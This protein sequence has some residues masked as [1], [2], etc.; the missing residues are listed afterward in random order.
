[1]AL[2]LAPSSLG[3]CTIKTPSLKI[4]SPAKFRTHQE[5]AGAGRECLIRQE[6]ERQQREIEV[7]RSL[8]Q[9]Q[10]LRAEEAEK[11]R[12]EERKSGKFR[13]TLIRTL[14]VV[15]LLA[16]GGM[17]FGFL[18]KTAA[19]KQ[20]REA[21]AAR[22]K[23]ESNNR[24]LRSLLEEAARS[25][26]LL[27]QEKLA[28]G[29]A[30]VALAHL[31]RAITYEPGSTLVSEIAFAALNDWRFPLPMATLQG[32]E[33]WVS[34][35]QFSPDGKRIVTASW[36]KTARLWETE[37]GKLLATLQGHEG[38]VY[39]AQFSPDGKRI[40]TASLD[41][42]ARLW[43][44]ESGKLLATLQGH[45]NWVSSAQF[46]PDGKR[47]V[48]ASSDKTARLWTILPPSAGASPE[49]F[50][51]FLQYLAQRRLNKDGELMWI[52]STEL[53]TIHD[54]LA[55]AAHGSSTEGETPYLR[56][57]RHFVH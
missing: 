54:R 32:H 16:I 36:D 1:M 34:S 35:A 23:F 3:R 51:D 22:D 5:Q 9:E 53:A 42:T 50:R 45:E 40:V 49:W 52:P 55:M 20:K 44:T 46:S 41:K 39:N 33:D 31:A 57:L 37:S 14:T 15:A 25:D 11:R 6:K 10:R 13:E 17:I 30:P 19:D 28:A 56:V 4:L 18:Q 27:A 48:T 2:A 7:A 26:R 47:I 21:V 24:V 29:E 12:Q 38:W 8:A 43:E